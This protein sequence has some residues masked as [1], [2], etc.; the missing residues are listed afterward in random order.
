VQV[1]KGPRPVQLAV[2][3]TG[4]GKVHGGSG[5][6]HTRQRLARTQ[7]MRNSRGTNVNSVETE[8]QRYVSPAVQQAQQGP[9]HRGEARSDGGR[10]IPAA[11]ARQAGQAARTQNYM[12]VH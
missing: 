5:Y 7:E 10:A 11:S 9:Y 6:E 8:F 12:N 2:S 4:K 1:G 3:Q